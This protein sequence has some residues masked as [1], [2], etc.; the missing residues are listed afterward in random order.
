MTDDRDFLDPDEVIRAAYGVDLEL[1][2]ALTVAYGVS[3]SEDPDSF[4]LPRAFSGGTVT[5]EEID[6]W[7]SAWFSELNESIARARDD[8][9]TGSW[10]VFTAF[11]DR[12]LVKLNSKGVV[13]R[14]AFLAYKAAP[15]GMFWAVRDPFVASGGNHEQWAQL[16][17]RAVEEL[18]RRLLSEHV[19]GLEV[20]E[21]EDQ[22]RDRW[23]TGR[24]CD[25]V[26]LGSEWIAIDFVYRQFTKA[27]TALGNFDD[28]LVDL[29]RA[30]VSKFVQID[31]TLRRG[32]AVEEAPEL[33]IPLVV[34][35]G[36]F[37]VKPP[38]L[39]HVERLIGYMEMVAAWDPAMLRSDLQS[40]PWFL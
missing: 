36:P 20:L 30:A 24:T 15:T 12:P 22:I 10:W 27:T 25:V 16:F 11:F 38:L 17:G 8:L 18:G 29:K 33:M 2:W 23:G 28:L 40:R 14:P 34:T 19:D 9:A 31:E 37:P 7:A 6:K 32:L 21:N 3:S 35:G 13:P 5:N 1:F 26:L 39:G 4:V